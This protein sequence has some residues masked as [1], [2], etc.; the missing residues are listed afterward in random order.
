MLRNARAALR[1]RR[2]LGRVQPRLPVRQFARLGASLFDGGAQA[3]DPDADLPRCPADYATGPD[4]FERRK[5]PPGLIAI[6][7]GAGDE[8][9]AHRR[10]IETMAAETAGQPDARTDLADLRHAVHRDSQSTGPGIV[11]LD[12]AELRISAFNVGLQ[13]SDVAARVA[14]PSRGAAGQHQAIATDDA[15]VI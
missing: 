12:I 2:R 14:R 10:G 8:I 13:R 7:D 4:Q 1:R 9:A 5:Q 6:D 3:F 15:I 11:D